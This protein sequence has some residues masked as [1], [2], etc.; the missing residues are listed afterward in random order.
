MAGLYGL[1]KSAGFAADL[2]EAQIN[3]EN[4]AGRS[5]YWHPWQ[6]SC[7]YAVG[8]MQIVPS[9]WGAGSLLDSLGLWP[10]FGVAEDSTGLY[11]PRTNIDVGCRIMRYLLGRARANGFGYDSALASYN[12]GYIGYALADHPQAGIEYASIIVGAAR[13]KYHTRVG[14]TVG[15]GAALAAKLLV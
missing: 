3:M 15:A 10:D 11:D 5:A 1:D 12:S 9:E 13:A 8:L 4:G 14:L 6:T 2:V 7:R